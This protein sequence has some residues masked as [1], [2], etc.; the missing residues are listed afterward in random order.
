MRGEHGD[1]QNHS[2][3]CADERNERAQY[4]RQASQNFN[5]YRD[6]NHQMG[7]GNAERMQDNCK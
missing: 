4:D 7:R 5:R 6:P 3:G 2:H 1:Q